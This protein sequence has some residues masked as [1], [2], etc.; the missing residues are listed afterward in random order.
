MRLGRDPSGLRTQAG[1]PPFFRAFYSRP[2]SLFLPP[3]CVPGESLLSRRP[4][5]GVPG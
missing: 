2:E 5:S 3:V 4:G 1:A